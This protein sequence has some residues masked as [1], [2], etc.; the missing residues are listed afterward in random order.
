MLTAALDDLGFNVNEIYAVF[1]GPG[2]GKRLAKQRRL[3]DELEDDN[4]RMQEHIEKL[5][6]METHWQ[7]H[8]YEQYGG[9]RF[10]GE[11]L[12]SKDLTRHVW[13]VEVTGGR[14]SENGKR[15]V[16][17]RPGRDDAWTSA[18][19]QSFSGCDR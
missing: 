9:Q 15:Y 1:R 14:V 17:P 6:H 2:L 11:E 4:P 16:Y 19:N 8:Q 3:V 5:L 10:D 13:I 7:H 18:P 12:L